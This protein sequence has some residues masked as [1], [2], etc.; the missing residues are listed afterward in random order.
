MKTFSLT[1]STKGFCDIIDITDKVEEC[2]KKFQVKDGAVLVF[3]PGSTA[4][5]SLIEYE[6]GLIEDL[7]RTIEE[8]VPQD[9]EYAHNQAWGDGNGFSH[10]RSALF[11]PSLTIPVED[12]KLILGTWQNLVLFDF[13]NHPRQ[14]KVLIKIIG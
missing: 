10:V 13:D 2:L 11:P 9:R 12:S 5:L 1:F 4:G 7:K 8:I 14:R 6:K 3:V